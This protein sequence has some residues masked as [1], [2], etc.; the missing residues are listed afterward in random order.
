MGV[1]GFNILRASS[2]FGPFEKV[3]PSMIAA[4][5]VGGAGAT[6]SPGFIDAVQGVK[7][8]FTYFYKIEMVVGSETVVSDVFKASIEK[9]KM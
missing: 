8:Q 2:Q 9:G 4:A 7:G 5:G 1:N 3:N 6:Y